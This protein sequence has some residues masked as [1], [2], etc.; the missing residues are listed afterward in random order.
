MSA[1]YRGYPKDAATRIAVTQ[2]ATQQYRGKLPATQWI[3]INLNRR[4]GFGVMDFENGWTDPNSET[5]AQFCMDEHGRI[6]LRGRISGGSVGTVAFTLPYGFRP[7]I[8]QKFALANGDAGYAIIEV[9]PDGAATV[10]GIV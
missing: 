8:P 5:P 3:F 2:K 6:R 1:P 4:N 10:T 7:P 9:T